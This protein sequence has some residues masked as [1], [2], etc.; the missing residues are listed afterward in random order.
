[1]VVLPSKQPILLIKLNKN[2]HSRQLHFLFLRF[3]RGKIYIKLKKKLI[4]IFGI[5]RK[6]Q[7]KLEFFKKELGKC[8][9]F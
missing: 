6:E 3:S 7:I 8:K 1:M 2:C 9:S 5:S 4:L